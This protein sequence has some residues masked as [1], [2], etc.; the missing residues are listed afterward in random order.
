MKRLYHSAARHFGRFFIVIVLVS[1]TSSVVF[2][3]SSSL[4]GYESQSFVATQKIVTADPLLTAVVGMYLPPTGGAK[5]P[6][7]TGTTADLSWLDHGVWNQLPTRILLDDASRYPAVLGDGGNGQVSGQQSMM[8]GANYAVQTAAGYDPQ[9][10][11]YVLGGASQGGMSARQALILME[12]LGYPMDHMFVVMYADPYTPGTGIAARF[13]SGQVIPTTGIEG[14]VPDVPAGVTALSISYRYDPMAHMPKYL[15]TL[16]FTAPNAVLGFLFEHTEVN[17]LDYG[18]PGNT[19]TK[20]GSVTYIELAPRVVPLLMPI[21]LVASLGVS[22][23]MSTSIL[24]PLDD[25]LRPVMN[26]G[27]QD[28]TGGFEAAPSPI[29]F[30]G[31]VLKIAQGVVNATTDVAK[32]ATG[33]PVFTSKPVPNPVQQLIDQAIQKD[34]EL[35]SGASTTG[36]G[37]ATA[38]APSVTSAL[39]AQPQTTVAK[40]AASEDQDQPSQKRDGQ[41][42][43]PKVRVKKAGKNGDAPR[44]RTKPV[45]SADASGHGKGVA[46]SRRTT[47]DAH[48]NTGGAVTKPNSQTRRQPVSKSGADRGASSSRTSGAKTAHTT[49]AG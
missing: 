17:N 28:V 38:A 19:V 5:T 6:G 49:H 25:I 12:K 14:G 1:M 16:P 42:N 45:K 40:S 43:D 30:A 36:V 22:T 21:V 26:M 27:G 46:P 41:G 11:V 4:W 37:V 33:Q 7:T 44:D 24:K 32:L 35:N 3:G 18:D 20:D 31:Q 10:T 15:W 9:Q 48:G 34:H 8:M 29:D 13:G 2:G 39:A 23:D 47:S